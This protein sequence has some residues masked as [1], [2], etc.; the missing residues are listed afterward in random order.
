M[1]LK[2]LSIVVLL[3]SLGTTSNVY[4]DGT[5]TVFNQAG[6][7]INVTWMS[8]ENIGGAGFLPRIVNKTAPPGEIVSS[9]L[10]GPNAKLQVE[11]ISSDPLLA[12]LGFKQQTTYASHYDL[13]QYYCGV[14][15]MLL[16][17]CP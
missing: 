4:A 16:N 10:Y 7:P 5:V 2:N 3:C 9:Y 13:L 17:P 14:G 12:F 15:T 8:F 1:K 11:E 6:W